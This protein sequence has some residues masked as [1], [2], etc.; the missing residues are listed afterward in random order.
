MRVRIQ[1]LQS[2]AGVPKTELAGA[3]LVLFGLDDIQIKGFR[4]QHFQQ[5]AAVRDA[6]AVDPFGLHL[7]VGVGAVN[8]IEGELAV[9][10]F[11]GDIDK[12]FLK[13]VV[14]RMLEA[15]LDKRNKQERFDPDTGAVAF[16]GQADIGLVADLLDL[17]IVSDKID[18]FVQG[19][20]ILVTFI[21]QIP[22]DICEADDDLRRPVRFLQAQ[23]V[24]TVQGIEEKMRVKLGPEIA[25]LEEA[26]FFTGGLELLVLVD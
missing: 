9:A 25:K 8:D 10:D 19:N 2:F 16:H 21:D 24:D 14:H 26:A 15:V 6:F 17:D 7:E 3:A 12:G 22:H 11:D 18:L 4:V 13:A 5:T 1:G 20:G 23:G